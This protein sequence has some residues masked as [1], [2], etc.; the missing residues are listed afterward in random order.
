M[1][2][3]TL[4]FDTMEEAANFLLARHAAAVTIAVQEAPIPEKRKPGRPKNKMEDTP[5]EVP[6]EPKTAEPENVRIYT[7]E[8]VRIRLSEVMDRTG[9]GSDAVVAI[10]SAR[11]AAKMSELKEEDYPAVMAH[12]DKILAGK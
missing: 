6:A 11:N 7:R 10:L 5:P 12:A 8:E 1:L 4:Q 2:T 3:V 9:A